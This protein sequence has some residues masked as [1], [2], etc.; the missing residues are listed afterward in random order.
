[1]KGDVQGAMGVAS[2]MKKYMPGDVSGYWI[3][4]NCYLQQRN[5]QMALNE[6]QA[7]VAIQP[8]APAYQLMAQIYQA[9][10]QSQAAQQCL[11]I[12]SQLQ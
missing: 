8:F 7:L 6:L 11:N 5:L 9:A 4:A 3:A 2:Q 12:A 10:G 1:M